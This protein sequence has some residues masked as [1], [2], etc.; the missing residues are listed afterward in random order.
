MKKTKFSIII[1]AYNVEKYIKET[2]QSVLNQT[3]DNYEIIVIND[4][5]TDKTEEVIKSIKDKRIKL[6]NQNNK[7]VSAARNNG[8]KHATGDY[9]IFIDSD[10]Y[11]ED[12]ALEYVN[13]KI[14]ENKK[15]TTFVGS[16]NTVYDKGCY[17][18]CKCEELEAEYINGKDKASVI[19]YL[20]SKRII[21]T[22]W[23][24]VVSRKLIID[25]NLFFKEGIIHEDEE[26]VP[27]LLAA[28]KNF[29]LL[30]RIYYNYRI[31]KKSIM[32]LN[33]NDLYREECL[34][35]VSEELLNKAKNTKNITNKKI[36][37]RNSYKNLFQ[38]YLKIREKAYPIEPNLTEKNRI[39]KN[40]VI[41]GTSRSGKTTLANI[42][43]GEMRYSV[44]STDNIV[45]AFQNGMPELEITHHNRDGKSVKNLQNFLEAYMHSLNG[46]DQKTKMFNYVFEG[47][48]FSEETIK[49]CLEK[50]VVVVLVNGYKSPKE[51]FDNI[52]KYDGPHDWTQ[53]YDDEKL[54]NYCINLYNSEKNIIDMCKRLNIKYFVTGKN[55]T[56]TLDEL[57]LILKAEVTE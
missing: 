45:S 43:K 18:N 14:N 31:R 7:G 6:V 19:D 5:S 57:L 17:R 3:Y 44:I 20:Y 27:S 50:Y 1:P 2:I 56:K 37:L 40:I 54:M 33:R 22:V 11:I 46:R 15:N 51:F 29:A 47:A 35:K 24:F 39:K 23:R 53:K 32:T 4:G 10:D 41:Y 26:W 30:D 12:F 25:N 16:F 13:E 42:I 9:I 49:K 34:I 52:R 36:F 28:S 8:I 48:Y 55:R 21:Y 38:A